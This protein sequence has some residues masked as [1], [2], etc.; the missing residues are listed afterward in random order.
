MVSGGRI[1]PGPL[2]IANSSV[3]RR[4][5]SDWR[6]ASAVT[7]PITIAAAASSTSVSATSRVRNDRARSTYCP[8][9]STYPAPRTV[10]IIGE[11]PASIFLR[12]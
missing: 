12:R 8:G 9:L 10:W 1:R 4:E 5:I 7:R 6:T 2:L 3:S 11:R